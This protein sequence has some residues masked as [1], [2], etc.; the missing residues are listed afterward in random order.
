MLVGVSLCT[1]KD[2]CHLGFFA[3][4]VIGINV[5]LA[6]YFH[7][8]ILKHNLLIIRQHGW[9][10]KLYGTGLAVAIRQGSDRLRSRW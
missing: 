8:L 4:K 3:R 5:E 2:I 10:Q 6:C 9:I 7:L 1:G